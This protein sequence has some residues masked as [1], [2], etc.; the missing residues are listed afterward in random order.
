MKKLKVIKKVTGKSSIKGL[1]E[2]IYYHI[3]IG[4]DGKKYCI[5]KDTIG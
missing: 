3:Y 5:D 1:E 2:S 4:K